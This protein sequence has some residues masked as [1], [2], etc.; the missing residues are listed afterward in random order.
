MRDA[1]TKLCLRSCDEFMIGAGIKEEFEQ[2]VPNTE[3]APF[4]ADKCIQHIKLTQTF[5]KNFKYHS[6]DSRVSFSL[7]LL[8]KRLAAARVLGVSVARGP[9]LLIRHYS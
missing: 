3:L 7:S 6:H 9:A 1:N 2:Y 8:G 4:T 5:T